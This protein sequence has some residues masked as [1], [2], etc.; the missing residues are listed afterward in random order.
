MTSTSPG[1]AAQAAAEARHDLAPAR[2]LEVVLRVGGREAGVEPRHGLQDGSRGGRRR[3]G[4]AGAAGPRDGGSTAGRVERVAT[5]PRW[6]PARPDWTTA[7]RPGAPEAAAPAQSQAR[8]RVPPA[9][10]ANLP[11]P[12]GRIKGRGRQAMVQTHEGRVTGARAQDGHPGRR[13]RRP[14]RGD[15][16]LRRPHGGR[17]P[18]ARDP[19]LELLRAA[20]PVRLRQDHVAADDRRLRGPD[21]RPRRARR[22]RRHR[23]PAL[24]AR[25]QH[26]LPE[27]RAVPAPRR[28]AQRRV[29][30]RAQAGPQGRGPPAGGGGARPRPP[31]GARPRARPSQLSGGQQQRVALARALV[32]SPARAA[33]RRAARRARPQAP[34][35]AADRARPHPARGRRHVRPRDARPGGGH[36]DGRRHRGHEPRAHRA[37][38]HRRRSSTSAPA[39]SSSRTSS[40][41]RTSSTAASSAATARRRRSRRP[42]AP[43]CTSPPTASPPRATA[44]SAWAC[45]RRSCASPPPR[46]PRRPATCCAATSPTPATSAS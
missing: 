38:G 36:V 6:R 30:A 9:G 18:D 13:R 8:R 17:R 26:G 43:R 41:S 29:R 15:E 40:G 35:A 25:R 12:P 45:A 32:N 31:A 3:V 27:L 20:R 23:R 21:R 10:P 37:D 2:A 7:G 46:P 11:P 39:R 19:A 24:Q 16:G 4:A 42:R 5:W 44:P 33:A 14:A 22:R 34:Q 1:P 28:G